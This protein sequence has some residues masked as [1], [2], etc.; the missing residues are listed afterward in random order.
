M[1]EEA[2]DYQRFLSSLE[3]F[4]RENRG[5]NLCLLPDGNHVHLLVCDPKGYTPLMIKKL[6][7]SYS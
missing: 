2:A 5:Q 3:R 1:F 6:G 7:V 4:L